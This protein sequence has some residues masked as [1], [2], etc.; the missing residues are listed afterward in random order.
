MNKYRL[1]INFFE[2]RK[3]K[4]K[5]QKDHHKLSPYESVYMHSTYACEQVELSN[6]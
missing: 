2:L 1:K 6:C 5:K 4:K 3:K